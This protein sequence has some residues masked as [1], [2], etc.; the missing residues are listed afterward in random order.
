MAEQIREALL[1]RKEVQAIT[2]LSR[3]AIYQLIQEGK[4][5]PSIKLSARAV[6]WQ[7]TSIDNWI[8]DRIKSSRKTA[9]T[10]A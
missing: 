2:G 10:G 3:S 9:A 8:A 7:R 4:F 1:R 5:P 6:A